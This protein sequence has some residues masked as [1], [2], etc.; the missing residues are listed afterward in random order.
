M[1]NTTQISYERVK[2]GA[3]TIYSCSKTM[4]GI[5][6]EFEQS[7]MRVGADDVFAGSASESLRARFNTLRPKFNDFVALVEEFHTVLLGASEMTERT[8]SSLSSAADT[9]A[10]GK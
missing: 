6:D 8:E 10:N 5:F 2:S 4:H 1:D 7:M 3:E 9:L